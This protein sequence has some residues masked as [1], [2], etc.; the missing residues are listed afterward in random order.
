MIT[1]LKT[2]VGEE[3]ARAADRKVRETVER[4]LTDIEARGDKA[5]REY[6]E[7]FDHWSPST[8]RLS[9]DE[10]QRLIDRVDP[11]ALQDIRFAQAQ[12]RRFAEAQR[13]ALRDIEIE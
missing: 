11:V 7:K 10:I 2:G 13:S 4:I 12:V 1:H 8:F 6:S 5:I 3:Q 9:Q